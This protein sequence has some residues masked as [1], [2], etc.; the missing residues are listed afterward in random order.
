MN[1]VVIVD[2]WDADLFAIGIASSSGPQQLVYISTFGHETGYDY[3]LESTP[4]SADHIYDRVDEG[5]AS[6]F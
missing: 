3:E 2:F 5:H 1:S 6:S 4:A